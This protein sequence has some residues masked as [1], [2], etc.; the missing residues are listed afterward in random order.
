M[1]VPRAVRTLLTLLG[2]EFAKSQLMQQAAFLGMVRDMKQASTSHLSFWLPEMITKVQEALQVMAAED[3]CSP[4]MASKLRGPLAWKA[5]AIYGRV[6]R[7]Y[8]GP[9]LQRD[10][11]DAEPFAL[12]HQ[13][14]NPFSFI[15]L[16]LKAAPRREV[17]LRAPALAPVI[18][19]LDGQ[20]AESGP[21]L[22]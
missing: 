21:A 9:L 14:R 16:L 6:A 10:Y 20:D 13:L 5:R 7:G 8:L 3:F 15:Q 4:A 22:A 12:S 1:H 11:K 19:C 2:F 18:C 17:V